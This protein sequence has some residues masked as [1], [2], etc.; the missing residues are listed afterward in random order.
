MEII[1][2]IEEIEETL[3]FSAVA[4]TETIRESEVVETIDSIEDIINSL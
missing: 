1:R 4:S 2:M 3:E